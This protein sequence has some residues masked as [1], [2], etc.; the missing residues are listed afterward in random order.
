MDNLSTL[1]GDP[2]TPSNLTRLYQKNKSPQGVP[3][4]LQLWYRIASPP[5]PGD[6]APFEE[7]ELFRRGRTGSQI[8]IVL[9]ILLFISYPAAFAGSNSLLIAIL[10]ID[11]F[12]LTLAMRAFGR[13][14]CSQI[15]KSLTLVF[16]KKFRRKCLSLLLN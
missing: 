5:E 14:L 13:L 10:T 15:Y 8:T 9:F 11:L 12:I 4:I 6:S 1:Q 7:R 16:V 2:Q 3:W